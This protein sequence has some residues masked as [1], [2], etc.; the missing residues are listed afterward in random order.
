LKAHVCVGVKTNIITG[1][2][3]TDE[4]GGDAPRLANLVE[5]TQRNF[6]ATEYC[7]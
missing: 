7:R 2:I 1:A 4:F 6:I 3:V 5:Q